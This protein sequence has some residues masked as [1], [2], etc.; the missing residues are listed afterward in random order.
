MAL[1][2]PRT[3]RLPVSAGSAPP[4]SRSSVDLPLPL[5]PSTQVTPGPKSHDQTVKT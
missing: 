4:S 1:S 2:M 3:C 5:L